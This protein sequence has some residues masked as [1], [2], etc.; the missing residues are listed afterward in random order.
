[1]CPHPALVHPHDPCEVLASHEPEPAS[2]ATHL[3]TV[4][5]ASPVAV[6]LVSGFAVEVEAQTCL[7]QG[8]VAFLEKPFR[9]REIVELMSSVLDTRSSTAVAAGG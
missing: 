5:L 6:V 7:D 2:Y 1:M 4:A 9:A 8:A 3:R